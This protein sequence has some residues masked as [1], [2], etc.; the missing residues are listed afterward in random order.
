MPEKFNLMLS[1]LLLLGL[2]QV[3]SFQGISHQIYVCIAYHIHPKTDFT[4][5]ITLDDVITPGV[6]R[7]G[8]EADHSPQSSTEVKNEWS[9]TSTPQYVFM[10]WCLVKQR[11]NFA[12]YIICIL[13][14]LSFFS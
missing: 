9:Y 13:V 7:L 4:F 11:D 14:L 5:L 12:L 1:S 10:A 6:K 8:R 3:T 2:K